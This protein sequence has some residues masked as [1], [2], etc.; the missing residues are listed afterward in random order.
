MS[1]PLLIDVVPELALELE[2][3]LI[4]D[5]ESG[6]AACVSRL[7][8]VDRCRCEDDFCASFYTAPRPIGAFGPGHRTVAL[9][10]ETG[11]LNVD[12]IGPDIVQVEVLF[13]DEL[14]ARIHAA[15]P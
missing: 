4:Q 13:R 5:G 12:A 7:R 10:A 14:K 9:A 1:A 11:Y 6:L 2:R 15:V 8:I 3:L